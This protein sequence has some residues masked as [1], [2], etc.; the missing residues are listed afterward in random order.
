MFKGILVKYIFCFLVGEREIVFIGEILLQLRLFPVL[1]RLVRKRFPFYDIY[2]SLRF[3]VI[4]KKLLRFA[5]I[6]DDR[7]AVK[8]RRG[9][10][11]I[12]NIADLLI[13][14]CG[15]E[16]KDIRTILQNRRK[17]LVVLIRGIKS[18]Y[19]NN[20]ADAFILT[21]KTSLNSNSKAVI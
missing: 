4:G 14:T 1:Q 18:T 20:V 17:G 16:K 10:I 7:N 2:F 8:Q 6:A 5:E 13:L 15:M 12:D 3:S 19:R 11:I 21:E 9:Y